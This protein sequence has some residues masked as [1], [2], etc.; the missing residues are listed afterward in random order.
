MTKAEEHWLKFS[1]YEAM[2][3]HCKQF[4]EWMW[5]NDYVPTLGDDGK[6]FLI[7]KEN[8]E[9]TIDEL[10]NKFNES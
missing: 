5:D 9:F 4:A 2:A 1:R 3:E 6:F 7:F 8:K 10:Y